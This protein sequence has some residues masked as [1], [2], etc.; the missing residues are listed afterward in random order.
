[1]ATTEDNIVETGTRLAQTLGFN[2]FSYADIA[3]VVGIRKAS[4]HHH[5]P[6]KADLGVA[7]VAAYRSN[8]TLSR[9]RVD[10][11]AGSAVSRLQRYAGLYRASLLDERMCLCGMLASDAAT[12]PEPIKLQVSAFFAENVAWLARTMDEGRA[13]GELSFDGTSADRA[14]MML[15][16]LQGALLLARAMGDRAFFDTAVHELIDSLAAQP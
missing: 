15:A 8:F 13:T 9:Q 6:A 16:A 1:V 5:F 10:K 14:K 3:E 2:A 7:M 11:H 4:I 12:L